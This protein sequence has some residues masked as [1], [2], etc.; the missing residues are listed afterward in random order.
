MDWLG[1][2]YLQSRGIELGTFGGAILS[3]AFKEQSS[4]WEKITGAYV[5]NVILAIHRFMIATLKIL[6][7]DIRVQQEIWSSILEEVL[8][9]YRA[10]MYQ[11]RFLVST[12]REKRPYTL[13]HYFNEE[14]QVSRGNRMAALLEG[15]A[16]RE[17]QAGASG[18]GVVIT[19]N[20]IVDLESVRH[21]TT[22]KSNAE[23]VKEELHDILR[24][25]YKVARKRFVDNVYHQAVDHCL[26]TGPASPLDVFN[27][28]WAI[29]LEAEQLETIA[30]E[31]PITRERRSI[32]EKKINDLE[33]AMRILK[34]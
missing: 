33:V 30:G 12:E 2:L 27:Q 24:S 20:L 18:K 26:L 14:L 11:A 9:R 10:A 3:R 15:K 31:S 32:L 13:N 1:E 4:K 34:P 22:S 8:D 29:R 21:A 25:Y 23:H 7:T 5:S 16:R 17:V 28:E 19:D 6:C